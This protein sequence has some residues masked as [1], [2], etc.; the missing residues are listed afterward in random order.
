MEK[1]SKSKWYKNSNVWGVIVAFLAVIVTILIFIISKSSDFSIK[2]VPFEGEVVKGKSINAEITIEGQK[3]N[4]QVKLTTKSQNDKIN[5]FFEPS[6]GIPSPNFSS[7]MKINV[8]STI[9]EGDY[10]IEIVGIGAK[11]KIEHSTNFFLK[12]KNPTFSPQNLIDLFYPDG[13]MGDS[14]DIILDNNCTN[15]PFSGN[16]CIKIIYSGKGSSGENW[17]GIYWLY[18]N[19]NWG[20]NPEG[21][22][23]TGATSLSFMARGEKGNEKAE[24][25]VG[26]V[27]GKYK[28][29]LQPTESIL[30]TLTSEWQEFIISLNGKDLSNVF[31]GFC[32]VT[33][34]IQ[35]PKGCTIY[36]DDIIYK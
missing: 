9:S 4:E 22:D 33:N 21:R 8:E 15:N 10:T 27:A 36:F 32:W 30:I 18:P 16:S 23:L 35:N 20:D 34:T 6:V 29:S 31:G 19:N 1:V 25:K 24:F 14:G 2:A 3:Y 11:N 12:V 7:T 28:D 26:G 5:I 17:A 13:W